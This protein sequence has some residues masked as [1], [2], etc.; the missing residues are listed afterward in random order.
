[1]AKRRAR[2]LPEGVEQLRLFS[3]EVAIRPQRD[4][5]G[6]PARSCSDKGHTWQ[7]GE[8][9]RCFGL[10]PVEILYCSVCGKISR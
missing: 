6:K 4:A 3:G 10:P 9:T 1:M 7:R 5:S 2:R 8:Q